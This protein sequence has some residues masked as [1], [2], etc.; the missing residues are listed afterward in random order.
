MPRSGFA[1]PRTWVLLAAGLILIPSW[2][3]IRGALQITSKQFAAQPTTAP[4]FDR[5][6]LIE[7]LGSILRIESVASADQADRTAGRKQIGEYLLLKFPLLHSQLVRREIGTH[8]LLFTWAGRDEQ[9][10][11]VIL[12]A[13]F[14]VVPAGDVHTWTHPPFAGSVADGFLWGRGT[15]DDKSSAI[16]ILTAVEHLLSQDFVPPVP[17]YLAFGFDEELGGQNGAKAIAEYMRGAGIAAQFALDEGGILA[18][19]IIA[20]LEAPVALIGID[21]KRS[22]MVEL[23][24]GGQGGHASLSGG[25][26]AIGVLSRALVR[27]A[28]NPFD[29]RLSESTRRM[30]ETCAAEMTF[31]KR[32][33][34]GNLNIFEALVT[35]QLASDSSTAS[36]VRTTAAITMVSGGTAPNALPSEARA[37]I[38]LRLLPDSIAE[39]VIE[40]L[41]RTID[42]PRVQLIA[43]D[44]SPPG[45]TASIESDAYKTIA[46]TIRAVFPEAI[47]SPY[48]TPG[49]TDSR[50]YAGVAKDLYR[51]LPIPMKAEDL[52]R[53]HGVDE[54]IALT[55]LTSMVHFYAQLIQQLD[56]LDRNE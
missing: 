50:H 43:G 3:L 12:A 5:D 44:L 30:L 8:G 42:D 28:S 39:D 10:P 56:A 36:S 45:P 55:D 22:L 4:E 29:S 40:S 21:E 41:L 20:G 52:S 15:L 19:G 32:L 53:L 26:T 33:I 6:A 49:A 11:G 7:K 16:A 25:E 9:A 1:R 51:F 13:H 24:V 27:I 37:S 31:V 48:M 54:R 2:I 18:Q 47:V 35:H 23:K 17:V 38:D 14:D 46:T 34:L